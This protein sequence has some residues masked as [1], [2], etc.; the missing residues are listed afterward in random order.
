MLHIGLKEPKMFPVVQIETKELQFLYAD[1]DLHLMDPNTFEEHSFP[2][3]IF[4][5]IR[6]RRFRHAWLIFRDLYPFY[7]GGKQAIPFL[8]DAM[9][10]QV[11]KYIDVIFHHA[12]FLY[13]V[14]SQIMTNHQ[15]LSL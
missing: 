14:K 1:E 8:L 12:H 9:P 7:S 4:T 3:G 11:G 5:G 6:S 2:M 13:S 15:N 10:L